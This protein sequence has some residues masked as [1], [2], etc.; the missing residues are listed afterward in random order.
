MVSFPQWR[1]IRNNIHKDLCWDLYMCGADWL[2]VFSFVFYRQFLNILKKFNSGLVKS[3]EEKVSG[4]VSANVFCDSTWKG[5]TTPSN[6]VTKHHMIP[7]WEV[8]TKAHEGKKKILR[9]KIN[10]D[11]AHAHGYHSGKRTWNVFHINV[12]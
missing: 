1:Q 3:L 9:K 10:L 7:N 5:L 4:T 8:E 11:D 2:R 12:Q 6:W